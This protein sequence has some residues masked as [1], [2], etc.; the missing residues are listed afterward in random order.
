M[1]GQIVWFEHLKMQDVDQVGGKNASL[2]EMI[3]G[4]ADAGVSV[5]G[6]FATTAHAFREFLRH[7]HL[8]ERIDPL[9]KALDVE[10]VTAL[11]E[12]GK[13]IRQWVVESPFP[14]VLE[15]A[16]TEAYKQLTGD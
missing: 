10:D 12:A 2:G 3:S 7:N 16:V 11:A 9:L 4:L 8:A 5:P 1:N 13:T 15:T 14:E 6:G